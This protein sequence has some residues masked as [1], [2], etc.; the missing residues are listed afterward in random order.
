LVIVFGELGAGMVPMLAGRVSEPFR[1]AAAS[2]ALDDVDVSG[3]KPGAPYQGPADKKEGSYKLRQK[4]GGVIERKHGAE[5]QFAISDQAD[6][7]RS[8]NAA[9]LLAA[10]RALDT[11]GMSFSVNGLGHA[12]YREGGEVRFL[13]AVPGGLLW[14]EDSIA[15]PAV[16]TNPGEEP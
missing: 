14:P 16:K 3:L 9:S 5:F 7:P 10:W 11:A 4:H 13:A 12:W 8:Q 6:D 1:V 2:E 15:A